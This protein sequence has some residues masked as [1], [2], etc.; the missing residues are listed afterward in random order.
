MM[1]EQRPTHFNRK[2]TDDQEEAL[3]AASL[4]GVTHKT[5]AHR[6]GISPGTVLN[7][8][9]RRGAL[10]RD[11]PEALD[12]R[13]QP[14]LPFA[15]RPDDY[16]AQGAALKEGQWREV[17]RRRLAGEPDGELSLEYEV[18]PGAISWQ[19]K[20][21]GLRKRETPGAVLR[22][23]TA[24]GEPGV[25]TRLR[26]R[27][28]A[29]DPE[30]SLAEIGILAARATAEGRGA[31]FHQCVRLKRSVLDWL[32]RGRG[33]AA[34]AAA[35][36][37]GRN[38]GEPFALHAGQRP[39]KGSWTTWLFLGG[40]G[41]GKTLAGARWLSAR[42][43][44]V[45]GARLAM[46]GA[47][48]ADVRE[49]MVEG[50]AGLI[51]LAGEERPRWEATRRRLV[52]PNGSE[53]HAF[54]ADAAERLRGPQFE[55]AWADEFCA[56][57]DKGGEVLALLR[58]GLR[59]GDDPRLVV[60]TT[61]KPSA[62]LRM[63]MAEPGCIGTHAPT[64]ANAANL[65]PAFLQT[66]EGL[67]GGTA[68]A[69]QELEGLVLEDAEGALWRRAELARCR[70]GR[71][72]ELE[73]TVVAVDPPAGA[74]SGAKGSACGVVVAGR[75]EGRYWVLADCSLSSAG[76]PTAWAG[77]VA[78]AARDWGAD[79]VTA[80]ANQGGEMVRAV[81]RNAGVTTPLELRRARVDKRARAEPIA[82]L[83]EQG[84]VTHAGE[85][86]ALEDEMCALGAV[87][88]A[89]TW[90]RVDALVWALTALSERRSGEG[91]RI[92]VFE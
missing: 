71:P 38:P 34:A 67:Y 47:T 31:D 18:S 61:P 44:A 74:A 50:P 13:R 11:R 36:N 22:T 72:P 29:A 81:L 76:G 57:G 87:G 46:V 30:A 25:I 3:A 37:G 86:G 43:E 9:K 64:R 79:E 53:A 32:G 62:S 68:R 41:A 12:A 75:R 40:R 65:A 84:R 51:G 77:A 83:Y 60:T 2:L 24:D 90:D 85:F 56:W 20:A 5:L 49:V 23:R 91:P 10:K 88:A 92:R 89:G 63:L 1:D 54:S 4:Q 45:K 55:A 8:V 78:K 58:M 7:I 73:R 39:P 69:A 14:P 80:E 70:G 21:R 17:M 19:A 59:L 48:L 15:D 28:D 33:A 82:A 27:F 35:A 16:R 26:F 42:A 6:W 66:L 52:W